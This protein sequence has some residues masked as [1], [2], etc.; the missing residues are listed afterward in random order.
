MPLRYARSDDADPTV[1]AMLLTDDGASIV[2][3]GGRVS[4][5]MLYETDLLTPTSRVTMTSSG[6]AAS[7]QQRSPSA[8]YSGYWELR[9][10]SAVLPLG[11]SNPMLAVAEDAIQSVANDR[12]MLCTLRDAVRV[13]QVLDAIEESLR[14][15]EWMEVRHEW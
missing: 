13:H 5:Y 7:W 1:D 15:H 11:L 14:T 10:A 9:A 6:A 12:P 4:D 3:L 8:M 2:L